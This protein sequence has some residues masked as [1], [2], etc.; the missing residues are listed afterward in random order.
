MSGQ[1]KMSCSS[2]HVSNSMEL[3]CFVKILWRI[4]SHL[5]VAKII[6]YLGKYKTVTVTI[7]NFKNYKL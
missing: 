3:E 4:Y 5:Y 1:K 2:L 6:T 7:H